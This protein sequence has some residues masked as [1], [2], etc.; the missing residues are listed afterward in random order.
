NHVS[1]FLLNQERA[2]RLVQFHARDQ[3]NPGLAEVIDKILIATWK[4]P[5]A[6]G[7][8]GEIQHTVDVVILSDL[9]AL[10]SGEGTSNQVRAI[11]SWKLEQLK[12]WLAAQ[13][14]LAAD[15]NRRAFLF[16]SIEQIKRFQDD[17]KKMNLTP[18]QQPPEGQPIGMEPQMNT[19]FC[20]IETDPNPY[21]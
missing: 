2:A 20:W 19:D 8:A 4:A 3:R 13:S 5:A 9:M 10:A 11:A 6:T 18:A 16:Y 12:S 15:D 7:Y 14:R 17:P 21:P 1:G